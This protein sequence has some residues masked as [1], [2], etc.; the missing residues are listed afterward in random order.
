MQ[1]PLVRG[2][3]SSILIGGQSFIFVEIRLYSY[4]LIIYIKETL[5]NDNYKNISIFFLF[6]DINFNEGNLPFSF[7]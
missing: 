1:H 3:R 5:F 4:L 7:N 6:S 2:V